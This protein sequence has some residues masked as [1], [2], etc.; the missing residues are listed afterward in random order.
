MKRLLMVFL[1]GLQ[2]AAYAGALTPEEKR[3]EFTALAAFVRT[4][5]GPLDLKM[6]T[7]KVDLT[8]MVDRYSQQAAN[9]T[10]LE[11]YYLV[12]KFVAEFRDSHFGARLNSNRVSKLGFLVD[13]IEKKA[14]IDEID[15]SVLSTASFPFAKGDELVSLGGKPAADLVIELGK[16]LNSGNVETNARGATQLLTFRSG[17]IVPV[18]KGKVELEIRR[19]TSNLVEKVTLEWQQ[20]GDD[21]LG[22]EPTWNARALKPM[23]YADLSVDFDGLPKAEKSF[24]CSPETRVAIPKDATK[25][26]DKPFVA[27]YHPTA[28]G[29]V[30]Y[31]RIPHYSWNDSQGKSVNEL[32]FK[33][34]EYAIYK[35][36]QNTVGL[37]IDQDHNCGGSVSLVENM[38]SL[39]ASKPFAGLQFKF[40]ATRGEYLLFKSWANEESQKTMDGAGFQEVFDLMKVAFSKNERTTALTSFTGS[41]IKQPNSVRYTKPVLILADEMSGSGGDAF[42]AMMQ[43]NGFAKVAGSRTMG[44]GG[45]VEEFSPL[46]YSANTVRITKSLFFHPNGTPIENNG[47]T[48]DFPLSTNRDDFV[49]EY[50]GYQKR[51]ED[52]LL[53]MIP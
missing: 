4:H 53:Q 9:A 16:H 47:V 51:Y 50:K 48:P 29:N 43:G 10:N 35:L 40:L 5:Y 2:M 1:A 36:Q 52:I 46:N 18:Q 25:I 39:F 37:V 38:V 20:S 13:R 30:G 19:G 41:L 49:Y 17:N 45:H 23:D 12:N 21:F 32:R 26:F 15:R 31:L 11:F 44:A 6:Q 28:K 14:L 24:R 7:L 27:Y 33:Q 22:E 8:E 42:P 3:D 34:Y